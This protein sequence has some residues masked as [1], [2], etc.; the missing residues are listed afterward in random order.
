MMSI[1]LTAKTVRMY[2]VI[3]EDDSHNAVLSEPLHDIPQ[4]NSA[5]INTGREKMKPHARG[6]YIAICCNIKLSKLGCSVN[7]RQP[8]LGGFCTLSI[9]LARA[10]KAAYS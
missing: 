3:H 10:L 9:A 6:C 8:Q 7:L 1:V 2:L 4:T 5:N